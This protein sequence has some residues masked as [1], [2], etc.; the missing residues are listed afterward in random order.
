MMVAKILVGGGTSLPLE[1]P[2]QTT[3]SQMIAR[4]TGNSRP[5]RQVPAQPRR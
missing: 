3:I 4:P 1:T 5:E 2:D